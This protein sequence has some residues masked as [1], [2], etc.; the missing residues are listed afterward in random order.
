MTRSP[1]NVVFLFCLVL[2]L[3]SC[4]GTK[5]KEKKNWVDEAEE[6]FMDDCRS[7]VKRN[8]KFDRDKYCA[9]LLHKLKTTYTPVEA[10]KLTGKEVKEIGEDCRRK[11]STDN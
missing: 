11:Y 9:C 4:A 3:G 1:I 5:T 10:S 6:E 2:F 8:S 7:K